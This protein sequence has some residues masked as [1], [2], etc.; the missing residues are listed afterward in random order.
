MG[1]EVKGGFLPAFAKVTALRL[2]IP[3]KPSSN[4][5]PIHIALLAAAS[6]GTRKTPNPEPSYIPN[7]KP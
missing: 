6:E 3:N 7:P 2:S 4:I 5:P 1:F